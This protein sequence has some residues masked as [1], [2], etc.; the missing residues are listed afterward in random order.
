MYGRVFQAV[1]HSDILNKMYEF[2]PY[3]CYKLVTCYTESTA[4]YWAENW[5]LWNVGKK[6]LERFEI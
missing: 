2:V 6:Y 4:L 5:T 1:F 3:T